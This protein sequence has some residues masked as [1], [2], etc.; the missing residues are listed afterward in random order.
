MWR[1]HLMIWI[2]SRRMTR[3]GV[4][5]L[6]K[7]LELRSCQIWY[8][9]VAKSKIIR[10][11]STIKKISNRGPTSVHPTLATTS[12]DSDQELKGK[13]ILKEE[14]MKCF[15]FSRTEYTKGVHFHTKHDKP[16]N[17][18]KPLVESKPKKERVPRR[19]HVM[20]HHIMPPHIKPTLQMEHQNVE[21]LMS[22]ALV[23]SQSIASWA[24]ELQI[25]D[26]SKEFL[27]S[28]RSLW[29]DAGRTQH[30]LIMI[31]LTEVAGPRLELQ[32]INN[33][34]IS[35]V[36]FKQ[37]SLLRWWLGRD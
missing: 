23:P 20:P 22:L 3:T 31:W 18:P 13:S 24:S 16:I 4:A 33:L 12:K 35:N 32:S 6:E 14:V 21:V 25:L 8:T 30:E 29:L 9:T 34:L 10:A 19:H 36:P 27:N 5:L 28:I 15:P 37:Q 17:S 26:I 11:K 2:R 7:I 1:W